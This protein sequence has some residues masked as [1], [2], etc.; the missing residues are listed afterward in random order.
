[1]S[2]GR[3]I[4]ELLARHLFRF[5]AEDQLQEGIAGALAQAGIVDVRREVAL[6]KRDRIDLI[7]GRVGIEVK[8]AGTAASVARQLARYAAS[9]SLDEL[10]LVTIR[11]LHARV[12]RVVGGKAVHVV[13]LLPGL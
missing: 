1:V 9:P 10:V 11:S 13:S 6:S 7:A 4:A 2:P 5:S 3:A 12:P 8:V